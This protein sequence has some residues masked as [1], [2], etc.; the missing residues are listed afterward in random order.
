MKERDKK[1]IEKWSKTREKGKFNFMTRAGLL[2]GLFTVILMQLLKLDEMSFRE[3]F[4]GTLIL[5]KLLIYVMMGVFG[6][7][8]VMWLFSERKDIA[9]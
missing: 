8:Y 3:L 4:L 6:F 9:S 2:F 5:V 7:G 1:F